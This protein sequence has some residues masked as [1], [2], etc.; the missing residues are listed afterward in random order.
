MLGLNPEHSNTRTHWGSPCDWL[1]IDT[2]PPLRCTWI[3]IYR[4]SFGR[5]EETVTEAQCDDD[6]DDH[7]N[8]SSYG[9]QTP[10]DAEH[11]EETPKITCTISTNRFACW[12]LT[13]VTTNTTHSIF[14][15]QP[16]NQCVWWAVFCVPTYN[17]AKPNGSSS[18]GTLHGRYLRNSATK[19]EH[20]HSH[21]IYC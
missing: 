13:H 8:M 6:D 17:I 12:W 19:H 9:R 15:T 2:V 18:I 16:H 20:T 11:P 7:D 3:Y 21:A 14:N 4:S 1:Y 5:C 10:L